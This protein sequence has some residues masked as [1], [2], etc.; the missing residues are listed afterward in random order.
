MHPLVVT[1]CIKQVDHLPIL[2]EYRPS[3]FLPPLPPG[4]FVSPPSTETRGCI[5]ATVLGEFSRTCTS[6]SFLFALIGQRVILH[7]LQDDRG[8]S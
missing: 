6:L 1:E 4:S 7:Q 8:Q 3:L 2:L 5:Q